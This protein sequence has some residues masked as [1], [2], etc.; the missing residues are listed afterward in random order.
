MKIF[1]FIFLAALTASTHAFA[2]KVDWSVG[3]VEIQIE[4]TNFEVASAEAFLQCKIE[5]AFG[6]TIP[7]QSLDLSYEEIAQPENDESSHLYR[8]VIK[9]GHLKKKTLFGD[10]LFC[11]YDLLVRAKDVENEPK[12]W[13]T[14]HLAGSGFIMTKEDLKNM[15]SDPELNKKIS[16]KY[17]LMKLVRN[18]ALLSQVKE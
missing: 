14:F 8:T 11:K 17:K 3:E 15:T 1:S 10:L 13:N 5:S 2:A 18:G 6:A 7:T 9:A 16:E 12:A 4:A